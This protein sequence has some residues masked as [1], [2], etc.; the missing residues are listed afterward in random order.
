MDRVDPVTPTVHEVPLPPGVGVE[1]LGDDAAQLVGSAE[2]LLALSYAVKARLGGPHPLPV[3]LDSTLVVE[4]RREATEWRRRFDE[5]LAF[6]TSG[7]LGTEHRPAVS[8]ADL[9]GDGPSLRDVADRVDRAAPAADAP[10]STAEAIAWSAPEWIAYLRSHG[11]SQLDALGELRSFCDV[12]GRPAPSRLA[13]VQGD[14]EL[15]N[16]LLAFAERVAA[17]DAAKV[18]PW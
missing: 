8:C 17:R 7:H 16:V 14:R 18:E 12:A 11:L 9:P 13:A 15:T 3:L 1:P 6:V 10:T 5:L 2:D 4:A